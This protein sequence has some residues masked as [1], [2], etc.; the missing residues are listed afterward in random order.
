M[1]T[2]YEENYKA[3]FQDIKEELSKKWNNDYE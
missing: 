2:P 3:P 1:Q